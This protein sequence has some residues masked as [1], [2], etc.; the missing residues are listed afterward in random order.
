M[1]C[2]QPFY[3]GENK[4][5]NL[6]N[7]MIELL[8]KWIVKAMELSDFNLHLILRNYLSKFQLYAKK[9]DNLI[10]NFLLLGSIKV[11]K[12]QKYGIGLSQ[13]GRTFFVK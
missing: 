11:Q 13:L 5:I 4:L 10:L 9:N 7:A 6:I 1:Q 8:E 2:C 12:D 3:K